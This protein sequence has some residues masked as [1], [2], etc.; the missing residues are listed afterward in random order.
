MPQGVQHRIVCV[1]LAQEVFTSLTPLLHAR[2]GE[3]DVVCSD[4]VSARADAEGHPAE[5]HLFVV[6]VAPDL[7]LARLAALTARFPGQPV[8]ALLPGGTDIPRVLATQRAGASQVVTLPLREADF[9]QALDCLLVQF[10]PPP[11]EAHVL[12]VCG[13]SGGAGATT[14]ALNLASEIAQAPGR[15]RQNVLLVELARGMGTLAT[16]LDIAPE[17]TT[18]ELVR[19]SGHLSP[20]VI[21]RAI[22]HVS[23]GLGVLVGPYE[24][25]TPGSISSRNVFQLIELC[26]KL[27]SVVVLDVPCTLDDL[28]FETLTLANRVALV[29]VQSVSSI[30][31]LEKVR[32]TLEREQGIMDQVLVLNR[33]EPTVPGFSAAHI[34]QLL[35]VPDIS[36]VANDLSVMA[37]QNHAKPLL[38]AAPHSPVIADIRRLAARLSGSPALPPAD[39][40]DRLQRILGKP[41]GPPPR[42]PLRVLHIEDDSLQQEVV[43]LRLGA[44]EGFVVSI[45]PATSEAAAVALFSRQPFDLVLLDYHLAEGNGLGC[46]RQLRVLDPNVPILVVSGVNQP[47]IAAELLSAGADDFLSKENLAGDQLGRSMSAAVARADAFKQRLGVPPKSVPSDTV[48]DRLRATFTGDD[49]AELMNCLVELHQISHTGRFGAAQIQRLVDLVCGELGRTPGDPLPRR[50]ILSLFL[51]LFSPQAGERGNS[52]DKVTR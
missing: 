8:L 15:A 2:G 13:V 3:A 31:T 27:A 5:S 37:A 19:D 23:P 16:Y 44:L 38:V 26:R 49:L 24:E 10:A 33:Y 14:L 11:R 4:L 42:R 18:H 32:D 34:A 35:G 29:G 21:R 46:L 12:A 39:S 52:G 41:S 20:A 40:G 30:R 51:R 9:L 47:Q 48:V 50:A 36:T 22:V 17:L 1:G 28:Q 25:I 7:D 43:A 6:H 45:A